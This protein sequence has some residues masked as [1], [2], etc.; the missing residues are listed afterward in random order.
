MCEQAE[1]N[2]HAQAHKRGGK[3]YLCVVV[4]FAYAF[5]VQ[6]CR[7]TACQSSHWESNFESG[8]GDYHD[9]EQSRLKGIKHFF[10]VI[11]IDKNENVVSDIDFKNKFN[12][13]VKIQNKMFHL[14]YIDI[15]NAN[16]ESFIEKQT[17]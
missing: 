14:K 3:N 7:H 9:N 11:S 8:H 16:V 17:L 5:S 1:N 6:C 4:M 10:N 13:D 2:T 15:L 12:K